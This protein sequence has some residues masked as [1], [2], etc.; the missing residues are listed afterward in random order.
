[1]M[2]VSRHL[3]LQPYEPIWQAMQRFTDTRKPETADEIWFLQHFPVYTQGMAGKPE[4][5]LNPGDVPVVAIDRGGQV[6]YHGPGQL[7]GYVMLDVARRQLAP[8]QLV[9]LLEK[10]LIEL[11]SFWKIEA[12]ARQDAPGIYIENRKIASLGL[13][14]R[15]NASYHGLALNIDMDLAPFYGINPCGFKDIAMTQLKE[16]VPDISLQQ[17]EYLLSSILMKELGNAY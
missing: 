7:V 2:L 12:Y 5:I 13:R 1:M 10:A 16:F 11:L 14:I 3:G 6:T 17:V 9:S 4:H 8:R 15:R